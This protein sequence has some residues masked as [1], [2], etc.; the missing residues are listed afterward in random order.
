MRLVKS[1]E[2]NH[3]LRAMAGDK[4]HL[5]ASLIGVDAD[6]LSR[7]DLMYYEDRIRKLKDGLLPIE[8]EACY[9]SV[10]CHH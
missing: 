10:S 5:K 3:V 9:Y 4:A 2:L 8:L 1:I 7:V 6:K